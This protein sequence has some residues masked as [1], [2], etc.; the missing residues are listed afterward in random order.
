MNPLSIAL[1][2]AAA[3]G[4]YFVFYK[5]SKALK[6]GDTV[7]VPL[8]KLQSPEIAS[9]NVTMAKL[10]LS[11]TTAVDLAVLSVDK[12]GVDGTG[13]LVNMTDRVGV[14]PEMSVLQP[15]AFKLADIEKLTRAKS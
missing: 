5:K 14:S 12:N 1:I 6:P 13:K 7:S 15:V 10:N 11:T 8:Q 4:G 9:F 3:V 2:G